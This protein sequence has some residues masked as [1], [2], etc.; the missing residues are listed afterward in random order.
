MNEDNVKKAY[1]SS[2]NVYDDILTQT[3]WWS[4]LYI[5]FFW[6]GIND[7]EIAD[8]VLKM[9]PSDFAGKLLDVPVGTGIFT[10]GKYMTLPNVEITCIDYSGDMLLQAQ[11]RFSDS[12]LR[13]VTCMQGDV[14]NLKFSNETFDIV[15]SMNGFHAFPDKEK[16]FSETA[17]VIKKGGIFCGCFYIK[18]QCKRTDFIVNS[19]LAKKGWFTPPFQSLEELRSKLSAIY[20]QAEVV[21][22][23]SIAYFKCVK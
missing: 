20:T 13:N 6:N 3:K 5:R 18:G 17:R 22:Q 10:L 12:K 21:N 7:N 1:S 2:K 15:L 4:K 8:K 19:L 9:I 16:A 14:G 23:K 11:K